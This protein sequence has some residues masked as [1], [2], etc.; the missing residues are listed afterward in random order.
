MGDW[1]PFASRT[2]ATRW[3]LA[4]D[5]HTPGCNS[6]HDIFYV[7]EISTLKQEGLASTY[8]KWNVFMLTTSVNRRTF[9]SFNI[10]PV[11]FWN[12]FFHL[13]LYFS[14]FFSINEV[15]GRRDFRSINCLSTAN[16]KCHLCFNFYMDAN[17]WKTTRIAVRLSAPGPEN[18]NVSG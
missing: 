15:K 3:F 12:N 6:F 18:S 17:V 16:E 13:M 5:A 7:F 2:C 1:A 10:L 4:S 14:G 11:E 8:F 9:R